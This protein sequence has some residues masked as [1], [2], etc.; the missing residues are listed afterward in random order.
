MKGHRIARVEELLKRELSSILQRSLK[1]P[2]IGFV[3]IARIKV[4]ADLR[5][6]KVFVSVMGEDEARQKTMEGLTSACGYIQRELGSR[7]KMKFLPRLEFILDDSLDYGFH[8]MDLLRKIGEEKKN[9]KRDREEGDNPVD[10][11]E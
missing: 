7:V 3:T 1:D 9:D 6:A 4:S 11:G 5:H 2:R 10:K 8:I